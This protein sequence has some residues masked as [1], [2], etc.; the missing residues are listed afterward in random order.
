MIPYAIKIETPPS[1]SKKT[2]ITSYQVREF[3]RGN[4][5][6][7]APC[8]NSKAFFRK[9]TKNQW[10]EQLSD[11]QVARIVDRHREQMLRYNYVPP[12]F[13]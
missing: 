4:I 3:D 2:C 7:L 5:V 12:R 8:P 9:G 10:V 11:E 6:W 13:R 1:K